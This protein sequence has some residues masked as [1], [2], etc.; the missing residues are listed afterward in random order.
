MDHAAL[1][2]DGITRFV[3]LCGPRTGS[4]MLVSA[5]HSHPRIVCFREIFNFVFPNIDYFVDGYRRADP[6]AM[7]LRKAD[8]AAFLRRYIYGHDPAAVDAAGWKSMYDH[9]SGW[10]KLLPAMQ[11]DG[12]LRIVHLK[13]RNGVRAFLSYEL[14]SSTGR[15]QRPVAPSPSLGQ[16]VRDRLSTPDVQVALSAQECLEYIRLRETQEREFDEIFKAQLSIDV[17]YEDILADRS[18][19]F[20]RVQEFLGVEPEVLVAGYERQHPGELRDLICN[21]EE[22]ASALRPTPHAWMLEEA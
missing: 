8:P 18:T 20:R 13:R 7:A 15:W 11:A 1:G 4:N 17:Y 3:I 14:A 21:Y 19:A 5:L 9:F 6:K 16:Y 22:L 2:P 10:R 12:G